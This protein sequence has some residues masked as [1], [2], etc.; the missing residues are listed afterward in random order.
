MN[1]HFSYKHTVRSPEVEKIVNRHIE[2]LNKWL[3]TFS[4]DLVHL[5]AALEYQ[6]AREGFKT[7]LN[8]RLPVG[9]LFATEAGK[10]AQAS[11]RAA[12]DELERQFKDK[13]GVLRNGKTRSTSEETAGAERS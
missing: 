6:S 3:A 2:K 13:M 1:V 4:P 5:H 9:Q 11:M 12:F 7:S 8:L 10:T